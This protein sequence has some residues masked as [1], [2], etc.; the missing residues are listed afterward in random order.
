MDD[1][2]IPELPSFLDRFPGDTGPQRRPRR[3]VWRPTPAM[4]K[5]AQWDAKKREKIAARPT[6]FAAVKDGAETFNALR[7]ATGLDPSHIRSALRFYLNQARAIRKI[8]R[9]YYA[10]R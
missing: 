1:S 2:I 10:V 6:V 4:Q 7:K 3:K 9:R 5:Q 8:D